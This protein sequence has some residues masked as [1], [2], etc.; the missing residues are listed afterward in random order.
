M[1]F[2]GDLRW[3]NLMMFNGNLMMNGMFVFK[4]TTDRGGEP[5]P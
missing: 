3:F 2:S 1:G 4:K 5:F